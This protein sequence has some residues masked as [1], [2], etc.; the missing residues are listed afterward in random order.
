MNTELDQQRKFTEQFL[1]LI[2]EASPK[3]KEKWDNNIQFSNPSRTKYIPTFSTG[4]INLL[5]VAL[6]DKFE[7]LRGRYY[8]KSL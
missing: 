2:K 3:F 7:I 5:S 4:V 8:A 6:R 1:E